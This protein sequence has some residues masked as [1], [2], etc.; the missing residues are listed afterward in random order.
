MHTSWARARWIE[1]VVTHAAQ[2][3]DGAQVLLRALRAVALR[4]DGEEDVGR[5]EAG[6]EEPHR[7]ASEGDACGYHKK[8]RPSTIREPRHLRA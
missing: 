2:V 7:A 1:P 4:R 3:L 5:N 8:A 6:E